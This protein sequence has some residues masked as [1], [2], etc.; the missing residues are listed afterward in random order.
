MTVLSAKNL[1]IPT[2]LVF[3][4]SVGSEAASRGSPDGPT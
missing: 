2:Q 1:D 4:E 3:C